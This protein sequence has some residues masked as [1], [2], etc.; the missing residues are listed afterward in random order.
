MVGGD[1]AGLARARPVLATFGDPILHVG[2]IGAGQMAKLVNNLVF[3]AQIALSLDAFALAHEL[4]LDGVAMA[5]VFGRRERRQPGRHDALGTRVRHRRSRPYR[6]AT[7]PQGCEPDHGRGATTAD[8]G[9]RVR[10]DA[11]RKGSPE[12]PSG[13]RGNLVKGGRA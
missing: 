6:R 1:E 10:R 2:E 11:R 12:P 4:G 3:T 7:A 13:G 9:A 5:Q 8:H